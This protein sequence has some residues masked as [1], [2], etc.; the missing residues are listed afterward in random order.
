[1]QITLKIKGPA[2]KLRLPAPIFKAV[3]AA[4]KKKALGIG[5][6]FDK[7]MVNTDENER[8]FPAIEEDTS[9][10]IEPMGGLGMA[11]V[12]VGVFTGNKPDYI[13]TLCAE[14]YRTW[15]KADARNNVEAMHN[16]RVY[17]QN[18]TLIQVFDARGRELEEVGEAYRQQFL[19]PPEHSALIEAAF[20]T[21]LQQAM[22]HRIMAE[23]PVTIRP[24]GSQLVT[25]AYGPLFENRA[26][27]QLSWI[28][29]PGE[30][31]EGVIAEVVKALAPEIAALYRFEPGG[32]YSIDINHRHV[33]KNDGTAH[34]RKQLGIQT[35]LYFGDSVYVRG[36]HEGNDYPVIRDHS[37]IV[38]A[39]NPDQDEIP[40]HERIMRAG[41]GP[42]ATRNW[43]V[44]IMANYISIRLAVEQ[45]PIRE[46]LVMLDAIGK[47][48]LSEE[49]EIT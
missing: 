11:G 16:F 6:D 45:L 32:E 35:L 36:E 46:K 44:W 41:I 14:G 26:G 39:V 15:L 31:R 47:S 21:P 49:I 12:P 19:F 34:F 3:V 8:I 4:I 27:V 1:M 38:F 9:R 20:K 42:D 2:A 7:T 23:K 33:A 25:H 30:L 13:D 24:P 43:L 29:V 48:G 10:V 18:G 28:A 5:M 17:S 40:H 37:A 22:G